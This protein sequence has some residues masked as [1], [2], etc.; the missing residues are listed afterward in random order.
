[1]CV[2]GVPLCFTACLMSCAPTL[3]LQRNSYKVNSY[4]CC[5]K[6]GSTSGGQSSAPYRQKVQA[7]LWTLRNEAAKAR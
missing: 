6:G 4:L 7:L 5:M 1:V 3:S 2:A